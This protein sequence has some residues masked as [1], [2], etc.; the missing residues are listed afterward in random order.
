MEEETLQQSR[1][2][3]TQACVA[4]CSGVAEDEREH[5]VTGVEETQWRK[6]KKD[7]GPFFFK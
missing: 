3:P 6:L 4:L 2:P 5:Q 1:T 7:L